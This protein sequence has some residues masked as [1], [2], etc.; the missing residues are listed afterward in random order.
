MTIDPAVI[1]GL[2]LLAAEL[3]VLAAVG[4]IV[5]RVA[6]RQSD[7]RLAVAQGVVIGPALWGLMVNFLL[8]L[9]PGMAG[10][11]AGW[12]VVVAV[13]VTLAWRTPMPIRPGLRST[14]GLAAA[15]SVV[16]L[17]AL[18]ARQLAGIT[19]PS[20]HLGLAAL[21][22]YGAWPLVFPWNP[23]QPFIYH[24]GFDLL[25]GLLKPPTGPNL[26]FTTELLDAYVWTGY[27]LAL[28]TV[29]VNRSG[30]VGL[31]VLT[32]MILTAGAWTMLIETHDLDIL[33]VPIPTGIPAAGIRDSMANIYWPE[34]S[35]NWLTESQMSPPNI[36][37]SPFVMSY[38][39]ALI[40]LI[41][42]TETRSRSWPKALTLAAMV[43]FLG[44]LSEEI[45]LVVLALWVG[46]EAFDLIRRMESPPNPTRLMRLLRQVASRTQHNKPALQDLPSIGKRFSI[47]CRSIKNQAFNLVQSNALLRSL[48]GP[49]IA[50]ILLAVG[51]GPVS[52]LIVGSGSSGL[53]LS[54]PEDP[55]IRQPLGSLLTTLPGGVGVLGLGVIPVVVA[56]LLIGWKRRPVVV[57][58][59]GSM[60]FLIVSLMATYEPSPYDLLRLDGHARNFAL[61]AVLFACAIRIG[62]VHQRWRYATGVL[63]LSLVA[64]P[65]AISPVRTLALEVGQGIELDNAWIELEEQDSLSSFNASFL[66]IGRYTEQRVMSAR[67]EKY[68]RNQ[69][70]I[71]SRILSPRRNLLTMSTGR[72]NAS[73]FVGY[74]HLTASSGPDYVDAISFLEPAA[75]RRMGTTHVHA[76][77][78]WFALL[79][80]RAQRWLDDPR[81]FQL[82]VRGEPDSLYRVLPAF[83]NLNPAPDPRSFEALQRTIPASSAVRVLGLTAVDA[84]RMASTLAH[85]RL[86]GT[87]PRGDIHLRSEIVS[88]PPHSAPADVVIVPRDRPSPFGLRAVRPIWWNES[89][90]AY[91]TKPSSIPTVDPPPQPDPQ[92]TMQLSEGKQSDDRMSFS[93][94]F[95]DDAPTEWTG[96]DWLLISG[97]DLPWALPTEANGIEVASLAWFAGQTVPGARELTHVYEYDARQNR[98]ALQNDD[99]SFA[100]VQSSGDRLTP[101]RYVLAVRLRYDHLQAAII[102]VMRVSIMESGAPVYALHAGAH[103]TQITPCPERLQY[104]KACRSL[105]PGS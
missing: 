77:D 25:V 45:A 94:T 15:G 78:A 37:K 35:L 91:Q 46:V 79:P 67:V 29:L 4:Y 42:A 101:G 74:S 27:A 19:E 68:I 34:V 61:L 6:L 83:L 73:G 49:A 28:V 11:L 48:Y 53:H 54:W 58:V 18:A 50:A 69:T 102:P 3:L 21:T 40:V 92:F 55:T 1:P 71:D 2:L 5:A 105:Q 84:L 51:G 39:L 8:H 95:T 17:I 72:L 66:R 57:L 7:D 9:F 87:F 89:A 38:A 52:A 56:A 76:T 41:Y 75:L 62:N 100:A 30:W 98:I 60:A 13:A 47:S 97:R 99:G 22:H 14:V 86:L 20:T 96:Q 31:F 32:P 81:L 44:L 63:I 24:Y 82:L 26:A 93:A 70:P 64:W 103:A 90:I 43:G 10:A 33:E 65:S 12:I 36:W 16:F 59:V 104:T 85:T 80:D 23:D 88:Q